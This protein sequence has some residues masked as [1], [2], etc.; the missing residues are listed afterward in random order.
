M[1]RARYRIIAAEKLLRRTES[2]GLVD[3]SPWAVVVKDMDEDRLLLLKCLAESNRPSGK[4]RHGDHAHRQVAYPKST[5][6]CGT[7]KKL[8]VQNAADIGLPEEFPSLVFKSLHAD[9]LRN[10]VRE[11]GLDEVSADLSFN[12]QYLH[13]QGRVSQAGVRADRSKPFQIMEFIGEGKDLYWLNKA[14]EE[15]GRQ[16]SSLSYLQTDEQK[17]QFF[18]ALCHLLAVISKFHE[19]E[20]RPIIDLKADNIIPVRS[21]DGGINE[22]VLIDL[23]GSRGMRCAH[24]PL[25][26]VHEDLQVMRAT[27]DPHAMDRC[28]DF[29]TL[30]N[31]MKS[32]ALSCGERYGEHYQRQFFKPGTDLDRLYKALSASSGSVSAETLL[33]DAFGVTHPG[34]RVYQAARRE[35]EENMRPTSPR[36]AAARPAELAEAEALIKPER[37]RYK[38]QLAE[39]KATMAS[40]RASVHAQQAVDMSDIPTWQGCLL[41]RLEKYYIQRHSQTEYHGGCSGALF[42]RVFGA[43]YSRD[44][45]TSAATAL[46]E[47]IKSQGQRGGL[48]KRANADIRSNHIDALS[49]VS[50]VFHNDKGLLRAIKGSDAQLAEIKRELG[51]ADRKVTAEQFITA[52]VKHMQDA[53][54]VDVE[55]RAGMRKVA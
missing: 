28:M 2:A 48:A 27:P 49:Q 17:Q 37:E 10:E 23:D 19:L 15:T 44:Q 42:G 26:M 47:L 30:A 24:T 43:G 40:R 14:V 16:S 41:V 5:G 36:S 32:A 8:Y 53:L 25:A 34:Y 52:L 11:H 35:V 20:K 45:K 1:T 29:H 33:K 55:H 9:Y 7:V 21:C 12:A 54:A 18:K 3:Q 39:H 4:I 31:I 50:C 6:G 51:L 38:R 13:A 46:I 22:L